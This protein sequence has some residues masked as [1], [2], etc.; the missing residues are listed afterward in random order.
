VRAVTSL[1]T[2]DYL[3]TYSPDCDALSTFN[4]V[5]NGL[6]AL[7]RLESENA[8][9]L[10][11]FFDEY[12]LGHV[13][14][15]MTII[16]GACLLYTSLPRLTRFF[17]ATSAPGLKKRDIIKIGHS[18]G[19]IVNSI[20]LTLLAVYLIAQTFGTDLTSD[21]SEYSPDVM[22]LLSLAMG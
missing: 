10:R 14:S 17:V 8:F 21:A 15:H 18:I 19:S 13:W 6:T 11:Q 1:A 2:F 16:V 22:I 12:N 9:G 7:K 3:D 20:T 5:E 4:V